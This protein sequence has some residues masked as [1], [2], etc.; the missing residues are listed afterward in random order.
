MYDSFE[1]QQRCPAGSF[2]YT[3][4]SGDTLFLLARRFN[5]TVQAI[6]AINPGIDPNNLQIG[7]V[8]CIPGA[9]P[10]GPPPCPNGF[11][12]TIRQG[13]TL[14]NIGQRFNVSV[15]ALLRAN[16]GIDPNNLQIGQV[17]CIPGAMPPGP[18]PCP[19]GFFYTI[20]AGDTLF[21]IGQR[22][23]V[24]VEAL[25]RANPGIDPNNLQIGQVICIPRA[26]PPGP[27]PCPNGFFYTIRAGDTLFNIGQR[28]NVS[29]EA[30]LRANPGIDPNN[31][32][33]GQVICIP[34][35]IPPIP[36]CRNGFFYVIRRGDTL[37]NISRRFNVSVEALIRANPGIDPNNLQIGQIICIPRPMPP[38]P[39]PCRNGF[40]YVVRRGDTF[41]S[42][43]R[44]F[45]VS[46][47]ALIRANPGVDPNNLQ[48]GQLICVP[49]ARPLSE[50]EDE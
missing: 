24:S 29:V 42:I 22:F 27:P 1:G 2:P 6:T 32:Q 43:G 37:F 4:R 13:D 38:G 8:I 25:L 35:P 15:E 17:I 47:E 28:F 39:P 26:M 9:M 10:P 18:P 3:I 12:Y 14:F 44:R 45:N 34:R 41:F 33:I 20:R 46:V 30:L 21:N 5:T 50:E 36:P 7:Q 31:L 40:F 11:F 23:N 19:N 48:I 49:I 16:P